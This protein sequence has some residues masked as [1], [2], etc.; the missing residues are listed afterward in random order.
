MRRP[1]LLSLFAS[2]LSVSAPADAQAPIEA[3]ISKAGARD[4]DGALL[5]ELRFLNSGSAA[6]TVALPD[7]VEAQLVSGEGQS[8]VWLQ[9]SAAT[10]GTLTVPAGSFGEARYR[11]PSGEART[12]MLVSIPQWNSQQVALLPQSAEK[13]AMVALST[14]TT[15]QPQP[16]ASVTSVAPPT[17]RKAGNAFLANLAPYEPVYAVYGPGTNTEARL[18]LSFAYRLFGPR[19]TSDLP[20][21]WQDGLY[22]AYTQRMF[23]DLRAHSAPFRNIDYQPELIYVSPS[24]AFRNGLSLALQGGLRHESNGRDGAA[25]RTINS[26]YLAPMA[27]VPMGGDWRLLMAPRLTLYVGDKSDNPDIVRYRGAGGLFVQ[28]GSDAGWRLSTFT[29]FNLS[30][31]KGAISGDLSYPLPRLLGGGP[32]FYLFLQGF[33]GYGENLLDYN[34][35]ITRLRIGFAVVR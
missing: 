35:S 16:P 31:G 17:D 22:F 4:V 14:G 34:R 11:L 25:S 15:E 30:S 18:Q 29:R 28:I 1:I 32:E 13:P 2:A 23:W 26:L 20:P 8:T 12:G 24:R 21:S 19:A 10:P 9:R 3:L 6:A 5:V 7:R 33:A 27:A